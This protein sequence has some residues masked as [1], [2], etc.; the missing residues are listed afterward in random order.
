MAD[1]F[2][3]YARE[4][5]GLVERL[6][7][8]LHEAGYTTWWDSKLASGA[9]YLKE[10]EAELK[11]A[12]AVLVVWSKV[13]V[14]SHWVA[15]EA[16]VGRDENRLAAVSFDGSMPPLG[17]RQFQVTDFSDW[18]G[19][20][21]A[22]A[23][24]KLI[25]RLPAPT[26]GQPTQAAGSGPALPGWMH[27]QE[28]R[29][30]AA[31]AALAVVLLAGF[32]LMRP[33][34]R[35]PAEP[36]SQ[37]IAFFGFVP[38]G[39][40]PLA[41]EIAAAATN[42][43]FQALLALR[44]EAASRTETQGVELSRQRARA[45]ELGAAYAL[46]G[47][48][49]PANGAVTVQIHLE[50]VASRTTLWEQTVSGGSEDR[51]SLPVLAAG[52]ATRVAR[53]MAAT[54]PGFPD[55]KGELLAQL[56]RA[57]ATPY[58]S[59][60]EAP[61]LWRALVQRAPNVAAVQASLANSLIYHA[62]H[63]EL[64][65]DELSA[66]WKEAVDAAGRALK[67]EPDNGVARTVLAY[68]S[69]VEGR[70][71]A[72]AGKLMDE[73][74]KVSPD[75]WRRGETYSNQNE[76][77]QAVGRLAE[78]LTGAQ[79]AIDRDPLSP[80][81]YFQLA[82][83]LGRVGRREESG[84]VWEQLNARWPD[85]WWYTWANYSAQD[86]ISDIEVVLAAAPARVSDATKACWRQLAAAFASSNPSVRRAGAE[87]ATQCGAD[88]RLYAPTAEALRLR[89]GGN[90]DEILA[91]YN[92]NLDPNRPSNFLFGIAELFNKPEKDL[93]AHPEFVPL[94]KK[95][96]VYQYWLD[97]GTHPDTC[98][99]PEEKDFAICAALRA[100]QAGP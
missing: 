62:N 39:N 47:E 69:I 36:I 76:V 91:W 31:L 84:R 9:R 32:M 24:L 98:D 13:S 66:V 51:L 67:L 22:P 82:L 2:I 92:A 88:G 11:A 48:V 58:V 83:A 93:R 56:A 7:A 54:R 97:T 1:F 100:D 29:I 5:A 77:L 35:A 41:E 61:A 8:A 65:A 25:E 57:C 3:S 80:T 44:L 37:R 10:T 70:P 53:C 27:K 86:G 87:T 85:A 79:A 90:A 40:D 78:S 12:K 45:A 34:G 42:E 16:A 55:Q 74:V 19:S 38:A 99:L 14:D 15:D 60:R 59:Y 18:N 72:E 75:D 23:F 20:S 21:D 49:R 28:V 6:A 95:H 33:A 94:M 26:P 43:T 96:G 52:A 73:A 63:A 46:G 68:H 81:P 71:L 17:F 4:D 64:S 30:G 50:D 89:L